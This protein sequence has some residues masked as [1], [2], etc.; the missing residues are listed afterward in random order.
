[1]DETDKQKETEQKSIS[2][3]ESEETVSTMLKELYGVYNPTTGSIFTNFALRRDME[4]ESVMKNLLALFIACDKVRPPSSPHKPSTNHLQQY[5]LQPTKLK[6][7][8]SLIDRLPFVHDA[9]TIIY[10]AACI[11]DDAC[12]LSDC[13]L[14]KAIIPQVQARLP[15]IMGNEVAWEAYAGNKAVLKALH[16]SQCAVMEE[17]MEGV[18]TPP[19]WPRG[20][21]RGR[22]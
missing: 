3:P 17:G 15:T 7:T 4:K 18:L 8:H 5:N 2:L 22:V 21:K 10:I 14:R 6:A 1:M 13:G 9:L 20:Q 16:A 19:V 11:Y 12:P